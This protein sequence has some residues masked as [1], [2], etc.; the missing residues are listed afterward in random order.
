[1]EGTNQKKYKF[2]IDHYGDE[3][4]ENIL[5]YIEILCILLIYS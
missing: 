1:M 5:K 3:H 2:K 4:K